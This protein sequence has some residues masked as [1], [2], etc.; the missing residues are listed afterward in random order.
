MGE[1]IYNLPV[2]WMAIVVLAVTYAVT[3]CLY[4]LII[5][6]ARGERARAFKAVSPGMLSPLGIIFG[7]CVAFLASQVWGEF[8]S[9]Q[10]AVSRE[11][12]ALRTVVL[13][14]HAFP[15]EPAARLQGLIRRQI[16]EAATQEWPAMSR[17]SAT[18]IMV[19]S[20]LAEALE[21]TLALEPQTGGQATAQREIVS[22]LETALDA[23]R[24]RI[25]VSESTVNWV[26]WTS[27]LLQALCALVAI[28]VVHSDNRAS[29]AIALGIFATSV[30]VSIVLIASH[31]G[32]FSGQIS[33]GPDLLLQVMPQN[34]P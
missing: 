6:A 29:A 18:L 3:G 11:A 25:I 13:L 28:A 23:R 16:D 1:W 30:A 4:A 9:A 24:Q 19:P 17:H 14:T 8:A 31:S 15:G 32:P 26:K 7:L 5:R 12:G 34:S 21:F 20:A 22:A 33:V 10:A 27:V 2:A